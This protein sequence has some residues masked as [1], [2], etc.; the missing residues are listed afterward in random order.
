MHLFLK[1]A[2][3]AW[4]AQA[5]NLP[6]KPPIIFCGFYDKRTHFKVTHAH[7]NSFHLRI[8]ARPFELNYAFKTQ[9]E[10]EEFLSDPFTVKSLIYNQNSR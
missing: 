6:E 5:K 10:F 1:R 8:T 3:D 4:S 7:D 2:L 9:R